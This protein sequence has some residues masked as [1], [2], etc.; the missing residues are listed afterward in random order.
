QNKIPGPRGFSQRN[1]GATRCVMKGQLLGIVLFIPLLSG[2]HVIERAQ[3]CK[4]LA[5]L[6]A[7]AAPE[8]KNTVI[9]DNPSAQILRKK[10]RLY[11]QLGTRLEEVSTSIEVLQ[12]DQAALIG[13]LKNL[14]SHLNEAADAIEKETAYRKEHE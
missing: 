1:K 8:I 7:E 6:V 2:C 5:K 11:G 3:Q 14:E 12:K 10:A 4:K 9:T 13:S